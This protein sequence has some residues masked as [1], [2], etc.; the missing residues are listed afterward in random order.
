MSTR[1]A[2]DLKMFPHP[3][4]F[5]LFLSSL[6]LA[7][8]SLSVSLSLSL[9]L[10]FISLPLLQSIGGAGNPQQLGEGDRTS[11]KGRQRESLQP[12][13][14]PPFLPRASLHVA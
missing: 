6:S 14:P 4:V 9:S 10:Y 2:R 8:F 1:R 3:S 11:L 7:L 13:P 5:P 12:S